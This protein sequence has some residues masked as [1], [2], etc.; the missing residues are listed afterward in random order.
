MLLSPSWTEQVFLAGDRVPAPQGGGSRSWYEVGAEH[1]GLEPWASGTL[2]QAHLRK[3]AWG[4]LAFTWLASPH[5]VP[6]PS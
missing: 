3:P 6:S 1:T 4:P 5:C 2:L